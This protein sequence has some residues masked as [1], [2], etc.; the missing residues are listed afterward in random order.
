[1]PSLIWCFANDQGLSSILC[2]P[3]REF[4]TVVCGRVL[5]LRFLH[6]AHLACQYYDNSHRDS[7]GK[8]LL[9]SGYD[10]S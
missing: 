8:R 5:L 9:N 2:V 4:D 1:M 7:L 10:E 3:D 6:L